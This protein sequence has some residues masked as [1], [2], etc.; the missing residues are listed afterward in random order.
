MAEAEGLTRDTVLREAGCCVRCRLRF[1]DCTRLSVYL[2]IHAA[3][4]HLSADEQSAPNFIGPPC[5]CCLGTLQMAT[6]PDHLSTVTEAVSASGQAFQTFSLALNLPAAVHIR[7]CALWHWL[8]EKRLANQCDSLNASVW[9]IKAA[10]RAVL[11]SSLGAALQARCE[12]ER[13]P[14]C[15]VNLALR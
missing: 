6:D 15:Q 5:V 8:I 4:A 13:E 14:T 2:D 11:S 9:D 7:Q 1:T 10:V 3:R 12:N